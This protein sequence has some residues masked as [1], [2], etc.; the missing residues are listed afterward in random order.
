VEAAGYEMR[1]EIVTEYCGQTDYRICV[2]VDGRCVEILPATVGTVARARNRLCQEWSET[3][4]HVEAGAIP[5]AT[6]LR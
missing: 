6:G 2:I 3:A 1:V 4:D 5:F